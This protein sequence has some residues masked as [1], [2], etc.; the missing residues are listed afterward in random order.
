MK[1][2]GKIKTAFQILFSEGLLSLLKAIKRYLSTRF[3]PYQPDEVEIVYKALKAETFNGLMIDV[4]ARF[5]LS[6]SPFANSGWRVFAFEPDSENRKI[7][8]NSFKDFN[9]VIIDKRALSNRIQEK[10]TLFRSKESTGI[11]SLSAFHHSHE[12]GEEVI[13]TTIEVFLNEQRISDQV[14]DFLKIDT[15]GFDLNILQGIPWSLTA[16]RLISCEFED[17]K[18]LSLGYSFHDLAN[19]LIDHGYKLIVSEWHPIKRYG[20]THNWNRFALYPCELEDPNAWGNILA[21][22]EDELYNSLIQLCGFRPD[23]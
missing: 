13:V 8:S 17:P 6:L 2:L 11:S 16:P 21:T 22:K 14:I 23:A 5:G 20:G 15:E 12:P 3:G 10:A 7:L 18:T 9:N 1:L 19:Y 4:G